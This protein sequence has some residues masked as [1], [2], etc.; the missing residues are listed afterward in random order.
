MRPGGERLLDAL[1]T[2]RTVLTGVLWSDGNDRD[3]MHDAI[4][5]HPTEEL[6]PGS[7]MHALGQCA[8]LD[9][10]ADLKVFVGNQIVR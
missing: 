4:G 7:I 1:S 3:S 2:T 9:E 5:F 6:P 10:V 8:V